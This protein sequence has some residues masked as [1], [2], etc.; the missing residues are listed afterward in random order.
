MKRILLIT[1]AAV[2]AL[3]LFSCKKNNNTPEEAPKEKMEA[4][5]PS[6]AD[7]AVTITF[8]TET[9]SKEDKEAAAI[10]I[11]EYKV[12]PKQ[13]V[14]T[15]AGQYVLVGE[16]MAIVK[17][18]LQEGDTITITGDYTKTEE[19]DYQMEG[20]GT[21]TTSEESGSGS[22]EGQQTTITS[23]SGEE[24]TIPSDVTEAPDASGENETNLI[25]A[26]EP[27]GTV[28]MTFKGV[29]KEFDPNLESIAAYLKEH[30]VNIDPTKYAGY[31]IASLTLSL[32]DNS[33]IITFKNK[34]AYLGNW[35]WADKNAGKFTYTFEAKKGRDMITGTADGTVSFYSQNNVNKCD[36]VMDINAKG[37]TA[38]L[39]FTLKEK[40]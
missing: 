27:E 31:E 20:V 14:F 12:L 18:D 7:E 8:K 9:M 35:K 38:K 15:E 13:V 21:L 17:A 40:K 28:K 39:A 29:E 4:E 22:G 36:L 24:T 5:K 30:D 32:A 33:F 26:W 3:A 19:G 16:V 23:E 1:A 2:A 11:G 25:R 10:T 34:E 6:H 37:N